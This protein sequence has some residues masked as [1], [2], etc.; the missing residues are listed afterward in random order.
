VNLSQEGS[1]L[2]RGDVY[3]WRLRHDGSQSPHIWNAGLRPGQQHWHLRMGQRGFN[4]HGVAPAT[5]IDGGELRIVHHQVG[6]FGQ[7]TAVQ[8]ATNAALC[9]R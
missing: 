8:G 1:G 4:R 7:W 5:R 3:P 2:V 6:A 9:R